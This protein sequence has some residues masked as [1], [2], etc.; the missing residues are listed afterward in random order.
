MWQKI[1]L[2]IISLSFLFVL[3]A[4][5]QVPLCVGRDCELV[6]VK[7]LLFVWPPILLFCLIGIIGSVIFYFTFRYTIVEGAGLPAQ[8]ILQIESLNYEN[9]TFLATYI[10]PLVCF[11]LDF[12]LSEN[13]NFI[14]LL[15][16]LILIGWIYVKT[17]I[18]Y[19]NPTLAVLNFKIFRIKTKEKGDFIIIT[20]S[21]LKV[22]DFIIP[23]EI[24]DNIYYASKYNS[25]ES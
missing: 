4:A 25:N 16:V 14:M 22:G 17:N 21:A 2:Y 11:D 1:K 10:I 13:R 8:K 15:L 9:L 19:T 18:Y 3:I 6:G 7:S 23:N 20:K 24:G 12:H 5:N